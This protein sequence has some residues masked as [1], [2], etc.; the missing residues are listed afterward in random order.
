[1]RWFA[2]EC[3][4]CIC[5]LCRLN[6]IDRAT[7]AKSEVEQKQRDEAKSRKDRNAEWE[8]KVSTIH[9]PVDSTSSKNSSPFFSVFRTG[10]RRLDL[11]QIAVATAARCQAITAHCVAIKQSECGQIGSTMKIKRAQT[12]A[13]TFESYESGRRRQRRRRKFRMAKESRWYD[14]RVQ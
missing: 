4:T 3:L 7:N 13:N 6:D 5:F 8:T 11:H 9:C 1:M 12:H 2:I 14:V 10:R